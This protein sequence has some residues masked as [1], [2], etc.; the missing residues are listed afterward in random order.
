MFPALG[1]DDGTKRSIIFNRSRGKMKNALK[2]IKF[3]IAKVV[4]LGKKQKKTKKGNSYSTSS[5]LYD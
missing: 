1:A 2:K 4:A 3:E 5:T